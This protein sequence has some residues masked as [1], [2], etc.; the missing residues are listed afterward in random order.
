MCLK[1]QVIYILFAPCVHSLCTFYT[2]CRWTSPREKFFSTK[3][4]R[5]SVVGGLV[6]YLCASFWLTATVGLLRFRGIFTLFYELYAETIVYALLGSIE[7]VDSPYR[8]TRNWGL[9]SMASI[10]I[11]TQIRIKYQQMWSKAHEK[12]KKRGNPW[13]GRPR[14]VKIV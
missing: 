14:N 5:R 10:T 12:Q 4:R 6:T 9:Y 1:Q 11:K 7:T 13:N 3:L 8:T 2:P